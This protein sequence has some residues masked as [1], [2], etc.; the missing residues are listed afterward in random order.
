MQAIE[1][2]TATAQHCAH[3]RETI[4]VD[5]RCDLGRSARLVSALAVSTLAD[6]SRI[7]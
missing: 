2:N 5:N 1:H 7:R 4:G 6:V 3:R